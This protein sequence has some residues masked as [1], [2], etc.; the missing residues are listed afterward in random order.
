M[1]ITV[2][3]AENGCG[4][5]VLLIAEE[6]LRQVK[7]EGFDPRHD[8]NYNHDELL[9]AAV[10]YITHDRPSMPPMPD[11]FWPWHLD[12]WK[13]KDHKANLI[14]AGA[15]IAAELDRLARAEAEATGKPVEF[16]AMGTPA[17]H[18]LQDRKLDDDGN[19]LHG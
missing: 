10:G 6:R 7:A 9:R 11:S 17:V 4:A 8:D 14:R 16:G 5:G 15:L 18:Y 12:W 1:S 2:K 13:P 19:P 3:L